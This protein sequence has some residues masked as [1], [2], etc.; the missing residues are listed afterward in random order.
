MVAAADAA[1]P[2]AAMVA[3]LQRLWGVLECLTRSR[4]ELKCV[5]IAWALRDRLGGSLALFPLCAQ[6]RASALASVAA[7]MLG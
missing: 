6:G 3:V 5:G 1:S 4:G 2:A 7:I